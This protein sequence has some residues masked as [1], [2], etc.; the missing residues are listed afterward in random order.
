[1]KGYSNLAECLACHQISPVTAFHYGG[2]RHI[3][4]HPDHLY[5]DTCGASVTWYGSRRLTIAEAAAHEL[6]AERSVAS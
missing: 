1:M 6:C 3:G 2:G 5:H 4:E